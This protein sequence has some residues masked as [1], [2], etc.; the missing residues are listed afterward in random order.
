[1]QITNLIICFSTLE[2]NV[3]H[4]IY[5]KM[6]NSH[7]SLPA[8]TMENEAPVQ[9]FILKVVRALKF[10]QKARDSFRDKWRVVSIPRGT[11]Q[12]M[13]SA[14]VARHHQLTVLMLEF[15]SHKGP[16]VFTNY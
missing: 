11:L 10:L 16:P 9:L 3:V 15:K 6:K 12:R 7:L 1:M 5:S 14:Q 13:P 8:Q 4:I 2:L